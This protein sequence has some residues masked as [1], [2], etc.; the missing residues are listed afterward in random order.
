MWRKIIKQER[1]KRWTELYYPD[2]P[3]VYVQTLNFYP[4]T[5]LPTKLILLNPLN[6]FCSRNPALHTFTEQISAPYR[7]HGWLQFVVFVSG[8]FISVQA[9]PVDGASPL[10]QARCVSSG[11]ASPRRRRRSY[12]A[13]QIRK[14]IPVP[15]LSVPLRPHEREMQLWPTSPSSPRRIQFVNCR[16]D[17]W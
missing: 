12:F 9:V 15:P 6:H 16:F 10:L 7:Q 14:A 13:L 3:S 17:L 11:T 5:L 2:S 8:Q 1:P 4:T